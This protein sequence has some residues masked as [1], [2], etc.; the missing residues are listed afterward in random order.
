METAAPAAA[1]QF[2]ADLR[3]ALLD[4]VRDEVESRLGPAMLGILD[5][6]T[7]AVQGLCAKLGDLKSVLDRAEVALARLD[8]TEA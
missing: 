2:L 7:A 4:A 8:R 5:R 6:Y 3:E 1:A